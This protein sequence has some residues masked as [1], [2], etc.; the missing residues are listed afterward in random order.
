MKT[1]ADLLLQFILATALLTLAELNVQAGEVRVRG[2]DEVAS[3]ALVNR[4][5]TEMRAER[6]SYWNS[7]TGDYIASD[8]CNMEINT[9]H[10]DGQPIMGDIEMVTTADVIMQICE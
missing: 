7:D 1:F 4:V 10:T 2:T 6:G 3:Y 8:D 9:V 5:Q